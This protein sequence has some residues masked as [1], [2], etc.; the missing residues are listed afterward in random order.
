MKVT[1]KDI[2]EETGYS[3]STVSRVLNG[4]D[5]ISKQARRKIYQTAKQLKYPIYRT[6]NGDKIV[7]SLKICFVVTGFHVGEFYASLFQ[8]MSKAAEEYSAQLSLISMKKSFEDTVEAIKELSQG[9][10][11]GLVLFAPE[12]KKE[13]YNILL[14]ELPDD[15]P[16]ISNGLIEN[17]VVST[18]TFDGYSGGFMAGEHFKNQKYQ[19]CGIIKGPFKKAEARYRVNGFRDQVVQ[20]PDM[21]ISWEY[22]GDFSFEAGKKAFES[23]QQVKEEDKPEAI[24]ASNDAMGHGFLEEALALGYKVPGDL[25]LI[26]FDDLPIC[27]RHRP[28][29]SSIHTDYKKLGKVT[30]EKMKE[31]LA[32]PD[33]QEG[34]LSFVPVSLKHRESS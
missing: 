14:D 10:F 8:G 25:A 27:M 5:K 23:F 28:T 7:D 20:A 30:I 2:A 34:I 9:K 3:I 29:I 24:F 18:V 22:Q 16:I 33:Q 1:L 31:M 15:F 12:F 4:S 11:E 17:P 26:G 19:R 21:E 32:N 6:L 13:H